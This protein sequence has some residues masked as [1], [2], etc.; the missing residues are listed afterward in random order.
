MRRLIWDAWNEAH[1]ARHDVSR[2]EVE[3]VCY[4]EHVAVRTRRRRFRLIGPAANRRMLTVIVAPLG[5]DV[6]YPVTAR[7]AS[8]KEQRRYRELKGG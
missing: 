7:P 2:R 8:A 6:F 3:E 5:G 1:I 4:G